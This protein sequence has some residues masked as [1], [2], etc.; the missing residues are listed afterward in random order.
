MTVPKIPG[1]ADKARRAVHGAKKTMGHKFT[2]VKGNATSKPASRLA[3]D[4]VSDGKFGAKDSVFKPT[5]NKSIKREARAK[6]AV[7]GLGAGAVAGGAAA[8]PFDVANA[9]KHE[10]ISRGNRKVISAQRKEIK[11]LGKAAPRH[12]LTD[13]GTKAGKAAKGKKLPGFVGRKSFIAGATVGTA[14]GLGTLPLNDKMRGTVHTREQKTIARN[15]GKL[16]EL[17]KSDSASAF[18]IDHG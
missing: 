5:E 15:K 9:Y 2:Q 6:A 16:K 4:G 8:Y 10:K 1:G 17:K 12:L 11:E 13:L 18:G 3:G 7:Y 14:A